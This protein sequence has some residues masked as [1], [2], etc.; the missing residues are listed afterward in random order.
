MSLG[1]EIQLP[2]MSQQ[3]PG[4]VVADLHRY[5]AHDGPDNAQIGKQ[6]AV[7]LYPAWEDYFRPGL[8]KA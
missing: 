2:L 8:A 7:Q 6:W 3:V 4:L 1:V 5:L